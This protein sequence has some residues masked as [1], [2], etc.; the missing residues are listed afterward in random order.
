M[1]CCA[2][3]LGCVLTLGCYQSP[4]EPEPD[5]LVRIEG[6]DAV[7]PADGY[8]TM[9]IEIVVPKETSSD[10]AISVETSSGT[11]S[12][13]AS[14]SS[15]AARRI[16]LK[17]PGSGRLPVLL[18]VGNTPGEIL[19]L[20]NAGGYGATKVVTLPASP[21]AGLSLTASRSSI[22]ADGESGVDIAVSLFAERPESMVSLGARVRLAACCLGTDG[23]PMSCN[24]LAPLNVPA[25]AQLTTGQVIQL[26]GVSE[27]VLTG[28]SVA[29]SL[30]VLVVADTDVSTGAPIPCAPAA[31]GAVRGTLSLTLRPIAP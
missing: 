18:R 30:P 24:G 9:R 5:D 28:A 1:R 7:V 16:I 11:L 29:A 8:S 15:D 13:G 31:S 20:A 21:V 27:R 4:A 26:R 17:N 2:L 12:P 23:A 14:P 19:L 22:P 6:P 3:L 25:Q 10:V